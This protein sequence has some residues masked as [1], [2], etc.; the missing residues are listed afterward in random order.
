VRH[1]GS[2]ISRIRLWSL[3]SKAAPAMELMDVSASGRRSGIGFD[4]QSLFCDTG[5]RLL[6]T[7]RLQ[8]DEIVFVGAYS[9]MEP[10]TL[11]ESW[12]ACSVNAIQAAR[13]FSAGCFVEP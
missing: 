10:L 11:S 5:G 1:R 7:P 13:I 4:G 8:V 9:D 12:I 6:N 3:G 2:L